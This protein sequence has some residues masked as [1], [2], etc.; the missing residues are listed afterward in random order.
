MT[1]GTIAHI[2]KAKEFLKG[3]QESQKRGLAY[4]TALMAIFST[5]QSGNAL[6]VKYCDRSF[7]QKDIEDL[8]KVLKKEIEFPK[9]QISTLKE[10]IKLRNLPFKTI[11]LRKSGNLLKK[12]ES[13]ISWSDPRFI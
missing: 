6:A 12:A 11:G 8:P 9:T 4:P 2:K 13:F 7:N 10:M 1:K 3:A 5:I